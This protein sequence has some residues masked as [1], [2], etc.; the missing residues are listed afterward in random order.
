MPTTRLFIRFTRAAVCLA[1]M[2]AVVA[3]SARAADDIKASSEKEQ[4]LLA[5]LRSE[6]P[7]ADKAIACKQ[8]AI[9]GSDAHARRRRGE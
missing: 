1:A 8:L 7:G 4:E 5:I 6:A 2:L 9:H 3:T